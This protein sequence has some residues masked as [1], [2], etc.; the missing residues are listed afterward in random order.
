M[1]YLANDGKI[2]LQIHKPV[3]SLVLGYDRPWLA[4]NNQLSQIPPQIAPLPP[5]IQ[6]KD[7]TVMFDLALIF[8]FNCLVGIGGTAILKIGHF[9]TVKKGKI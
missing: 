7:I 8:K 9:Q 4:G 1:A 5:N 2:R 6:L 3:L